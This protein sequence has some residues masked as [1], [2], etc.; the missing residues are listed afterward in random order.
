MFPVGSDGFLESLLIKFIVSFI[1][2]TL[3]KY[4]FYNSGHYAF[5]RWLIP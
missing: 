3:P 5:E 2:K 1:I 4:N